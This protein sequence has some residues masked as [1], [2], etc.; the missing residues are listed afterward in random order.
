MRPAPCGGFY[1]YFGAFCMRVCPRGIAVYPARPCAS[2]AAR[3]S[4]PRQR[5]GLFPATVGRSLVERLSGAPVA[6]AP[7]PLRLWFYK[8]AGP[9][10]PSPLY[11]VLALRW[12]LATSSLCNVGSLLA[13]RGAKRRRQSRRLEGRVCAPRG[14]GGSVPCLSILLREANSRR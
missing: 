14:F 2:I 7:P 4:P 1:R 12:C 5:S 11:L 10:S 3:G 6:H 9:P 13:P 8:A